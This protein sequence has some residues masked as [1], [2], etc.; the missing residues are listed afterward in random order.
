MDRRQC[1]TVGSVAAP[2]YKNA[3]L[4]V[5]DKFA[6]GT[7]VAVQ[8]TLLR[9]DVERRIGTFDAFLT[10]TRIDPPIVASS[11]PQQLRYEEKNLLFTFNQLL[12]DEWSLGAKYQVTRSTITMSSRGSADCRGACEFELLEPSLEF[13]VRGDPKES[14]VRHPLPTA[15]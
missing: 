4:L 8:V 12:G 15:L 9:S 5:E 1:A 6:S 11:T 3:G 2:T 14:W 10:D 13:G 7:C